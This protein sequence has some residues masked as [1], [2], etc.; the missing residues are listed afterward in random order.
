LKVVG[1]KLI[2]SAPKSI[3]GLLEVRGVGIVRM[4]HAQRV[5]VSLAVELASDPPRLPDDLA[6]RPPPPLKLDASACPTLIA[7][8]P[9]EASAPEKVL[10]AVA[11]Q[12]L[13]R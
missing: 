3:A 13:L 2:A 4:A 11:R 12:R 10:V 1:G 6:Y 5:A 8:D 9:F 7:L